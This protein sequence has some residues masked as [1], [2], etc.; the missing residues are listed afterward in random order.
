MRNNNDIIEIVRRIDNPVRAS[1]TLHSP[2]E[3][4]QT[5]RGK[6]AVL[7]RHGKFATHRMERANEARRAL[8]AEALDAV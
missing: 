1:I 7:F 4:K 6:S 5:R 8:S 3:R 2:G